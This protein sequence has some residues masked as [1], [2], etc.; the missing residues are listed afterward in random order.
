MELKGYDSLELPVLDKGAVLYEVGRWDASMAVFLLIQNQCF[1]EIEHFGSPELKAKIL[2]YCVKMEKRICFAMTEPDHGSDAAL[3]ETTATEVEGGFVIS[4]KKKWQPFFD[5]DFTIVQ[6]RLG[7]K[8]VQAFVVEKGAPGMEIKILENVG[9]SAILRMCESS[10]TNVF[11]PKS[12]HL[13]NQGSS[14]SFAKT[15]QTSR[16]LVAWASAGIAAGAYESAFA[17]T[18]KRHQFK[19]PLASF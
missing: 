8:G 14:S 16:V 2:P 19:K 5:N 10:Y 13:Q 7:K 11:V 1:M 4:G 17:H 3:L 15:L 6:A 18:Q 9:S 12:H